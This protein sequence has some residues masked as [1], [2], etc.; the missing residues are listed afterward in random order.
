MNSLCI[1]GSSNRVCRIPRRPKRRITCTVLLCCVRLTSTLC[2]V[3][4]KNT[5]IS[6]IL[7]T[8]MT[9]TISPHYIAV[10]FKFY[11]HVLLFP[12]GEGGGVRVRVRVWVRPR[13]A[14]FSGEGVRVRVQGF[15]RRQGGGVSGSGSASG[16]EFSGSGSLNGVGALFFGFGFGFKGSLGG[17]GGVRVRVQGAFFFLPGFGFRKFGLGCTFFFAGGRSG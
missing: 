3:A 9:A 13:I 6:R 12:R 5:L 2:T 14:L 11:E 15:P 17:R 1:W 4:T 16:G 10:T 8:A 7:S